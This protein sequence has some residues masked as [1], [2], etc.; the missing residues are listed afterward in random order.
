MS[1]SFT[2]AT[3]LLIAS[4][5][6][7]AC[8]SGV[9]DDSLAT[10]S[11]APAASPVA[12][13]APPTPGATSDANQQGSQTQPDAMPKPEPGQRSEQMR[14]APETLRRGDTLTVELPAPHGGHLAIVNPQKKY[15]F[16]TAETTGADNPDRKA[17]ADPLV[18]VAEFAKMSRLR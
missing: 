2:A 7:A 18:A 15:F 3:F 13:P 11:A 6:T 8:G 1:K 5:L 16:L 12:S 17:G 14:C 4:A 9:A 10:R